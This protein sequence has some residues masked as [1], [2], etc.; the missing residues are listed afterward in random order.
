MSEA[1]SY[2]P[3]G[4]LDSATAA[5][6]EKSLLELLAA[7]VDS[8]TVDLSELDYVSSAGLRVLLLAARTARSRGASLVLDS[9]KPQI[10]EVLRISGFDRILTVRNG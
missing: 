3:I 8:V 7:P 4:R 9:P 5:S 6:H 2:R 1:A 10:L